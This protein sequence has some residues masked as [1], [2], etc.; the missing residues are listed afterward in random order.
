MGDKCCVV[1]VTN[2][3]GGVGK[4]TT[5]E[6]MAD[7][8]ALKGYR[9]LLIDLDPQS[10]V[11]LTAEADP[12]KPT[13]YDKLP[14]MKPHNNEHKRTHKKMHNMLGRQTVGHM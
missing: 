10:S 1:C 3:K 8:L 6:A 7:G 12:S 9:T 14:R 2:Q 11:S 4:S 5:A 13:T